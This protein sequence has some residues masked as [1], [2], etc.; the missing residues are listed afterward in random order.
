MQRMSAIA[1]LTQIRQSQEGLPTKVLDTRKTTPL[2]RF[3][4]KEAVNNRWF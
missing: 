2:I 4:E 1:T 3:L